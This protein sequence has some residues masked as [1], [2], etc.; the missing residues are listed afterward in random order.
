MDRFSIVTV[1]NRTSKT[2]KG[3]YNGR[4]YDI[5]PGESRYGIEEARFFRAQ[6]PI[7]GRGTPLEMWSSRDDSLIGIKELGDPCDPV[8]QTDAPQRWD[9][10]MV[11]GFGRWNI[12]TSRAGY[13]PEQAR[14]Q[15]PSIEGGA[16]FSRK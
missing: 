2:L 16:G 8:E 15:V 1:V 11:N 4:P 6:N 9:S 12:V 7:M 14:Q 10:D 5:P 3:T 13:A